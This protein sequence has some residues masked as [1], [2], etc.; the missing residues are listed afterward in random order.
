MKTHSDWIKY[1]VD[2]L[3]LNARIELRSRAN[4][5]NF[6]PVYFGKASISLYKKDNYIKDTYYENYDRFA[7]VL[8]HKIKSYLEFI[9]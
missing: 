9:K 2:L 4:R 3:E 7:P 1:V 6:D 8:G 5:R